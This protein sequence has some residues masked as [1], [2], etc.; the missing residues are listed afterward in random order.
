MDFEDL[1]QEERELIKGKTPEE[2]LA[3]PRRGAACSPTKSS[4]PSRVARAAADG[5]IR[6]YAG[7]ARQPGKW[8]RSKKHGKRAPGAETGSSLRQA[9]S[10]APKP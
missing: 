2:I 1:T 8:I 6:S 5:G 3:M 7:N 4:K 9:L 10:Q